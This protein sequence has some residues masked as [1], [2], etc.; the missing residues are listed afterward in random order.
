MQMHQ[1]P[2]AAG[3]ASGSVGQKRPGG[4]L[5]AGRAAPGTAEIIKKRKPTLGLGWMHFKPG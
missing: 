4:Q 1:R 2:P 5:A 3:S